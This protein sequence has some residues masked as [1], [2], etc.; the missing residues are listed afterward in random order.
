MRPSGR[1]L[2]YIYSDVGGRHDA[3]LGPTTRVRQGSAD[4]VDYEYLGANRVARTRFLPV[5]LESKL[6]DIGGYED[7]LDR[8]NRQ[9][10]ANWRSYRSGSVLY[11]TSVVYGQAETVNRL[12]DFVHQG[13]DSEVSSDS[14]GR[15]R[16]VKRGSFGAG[17]MLNPDR[18]EDWELDSVVFCLS[19]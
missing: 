9:T 12:G 16:Q 1:I 7:Y 3:N 19:Y 15:I 8:F 13:F 4:L 11:D 6:Y 14:F 10:R 2:R 17:N 18:V 5:W